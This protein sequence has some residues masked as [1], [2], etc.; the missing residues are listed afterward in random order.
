MPLVMAEPLSAQFAALRTL[1]IAPLPLPAVRLAAVL[2]M[3]GGFTAAFAGSHSYVPLAGK[4]LSGAV[5]A[6]RDHGARRVL[7]DYFFGG[8][9]I[10]ADVQVFIESRAELYGEQFVLAYNN[11]LQLQDV[12]QFLALLDTYRSTRRCS[13]LCRPR[14]ICSTASMAGGASTATAKRW[15]TCRL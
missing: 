1:G 11:A 7:N 2:L 15:C 8:S 14:F 13:A 4:S 3:L 6:L 5:Q 9:L 12:G 10:A